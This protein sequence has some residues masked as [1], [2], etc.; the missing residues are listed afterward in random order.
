[1]SAATAVT[2]LET[3][4]RILNALEKLLVVNPFRSQ[5]LFLVDVLA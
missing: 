1:M 2:V 5:M 3:D 4:P